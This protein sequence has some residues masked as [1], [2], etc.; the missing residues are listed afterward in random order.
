MNRFV[1]WA[2][3][4]SL[5]QAKKISLDD[6]LAENRRH[7]ERHNGQLVAELVVPGESRSIVLFEEACRKINAY[8]QLY[9]LIQRQ[10]FDVLIYFDRSRLGRKASL[11][12]AVVSLCEEAGI[13][14]YETENPPVTLE[15][16]PTSHDDM[17]LGAIKSV[18]A[19]R[20]VEKLRHRHQMGMRE[21]VRKG[22]FPK[23]PPYGYRKVLTVDG[24]DRY[25]INEAQAEVIRWAFRVYLAEGWTFEAICDDLN[26]RD[27]PPPNGTGKWKIGRLSKL[28]GRVQRYAGWNEYNVRSTRETIVSKGQWQPIISQ[29]TA[30]A[31]E[32]ERRRR[33]KHFKR[34]GKYKYIY[35]KAVYCGVCGK[36]MWGIARQGYYGYRCQTDNCPHYISERKIHDA[37]TAD[38]QRLG[39]ADFF[40]I[41]VGHP[42]DATV[43]TRAFI[44]QAKAELIN[45]KEERQRLLQVYTRFQQI[46][47]DDLAVALTNIEERE[48]KLHVRISK[49]EQQL[50]KQEQDANRADRIRTVADIGLRTIN[51]EDRTAAN[52][53]VRRHL[54]ITCRH[55]EVESIA[56]L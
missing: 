47:E 22:L 4:S 20:E 7:I 23:S 32:A 43:E 19:Q 28:F 27:I 52:A 2:A 35:A 48:A 34:G 53:W 40:S 56:Y 18:G 11:S 24:S 26:E 13:L 38:I 42:Q 29:E 15:H 17:L 33:G 16:K 25:E 37:V 8:Q 3:V 36:R 31:I 51:Q 1:S 39:N 12:M 41:V 55:S 49:L 6:Q 14:C 54:K 45:L 50:T 30:D 46:T 10:A 9:D 44:E 5:P 21:R